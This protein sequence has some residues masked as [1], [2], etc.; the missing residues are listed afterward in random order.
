MMGL[1]ERLKKTRSKCNLTQ[2]QV[3]DQLYTSKRSISSY[4]RDEAMPSLETITHL[5]DLYNVTT[6]FLLGRNKEDEQLLLMISKLSK[7]NQ[8]IAKFFIKF[9]ISLQED[10]EKA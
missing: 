1:G 7:K 4:E 5:A 10:E 9:L 6:D 3:A 2:Q 8:N